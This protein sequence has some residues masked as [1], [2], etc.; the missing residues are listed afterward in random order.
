MCDW[1]NASTIREKNNAGLVTEELRD[2]LPVVYLPFTIFL[3]TLSNVGETV[4]EQGYWYD[5]SIFS[6]C[7][8][9]SLFLRIIG[10]F[11]FSYCCANEN[12][13]LSNMLSLQCYSVFI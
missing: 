11:V 3:R 1:I 2:Y 7:S 10:T 4:S 6:L 12:K 8:T 5:A 9:V 13:L